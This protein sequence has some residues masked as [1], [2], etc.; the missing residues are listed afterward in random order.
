MGD[1]DVALDF[2]PAAFV[3]CV[4]FKNWDDLI[5]YIEYLDTDDAAYMEMLTQ[6]AMRA[7]YK[8]PDIGAF[9]ANIFNN[10]KQYRKNGFA[11]IYS[12]PQ[13][14]YNTFI[15]Y[16]YDNLCKG[17]HVDSANNH[18]DF[19]KFLYINNFNANKI[20][21]ED[22]LPFLKK[23][24]MDS[25][26]AN[27]ASTYAAAF[28]SP[29]ARGTQ[30]ESMLKS[31]AARIDNPA[32]KSRA[33]KWINDPALEQRYR[34]LLR[35]LW[36]QD[37][38][39]W[40]KVRVGGGADGG[41]VMLDQGHDGVAISLGIGYSA[42]WDM[43]MAQ[44]GWNIW[45]FDGTV[46]KSP[47]SHRN[48][49]FFAKNVVASREHGENEITLSEILAM[50]GDER[51]IVLQMDI[52]G[53]EWP[54]LE[55]ATTEELSRFKQIIAEFHG[56]TDPKNLERRIGILEKICKSHAPVHFHYNNNGQVMGF[57]DFLVSGL[58]EISFLQR[59]RESFT[60]SQDCY[61]TSLDRPNVARMPDVHIGR[62]TDIAKSA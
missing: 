19:N 4:D 2:N 57:S 39:G 15:K 55:A 50:T 42:P 35:M 13:V 54:L 12:Q 5:E 43:Q 51:D 44:N 30:I 37:A 8:S 17:N 32:N 56:L 24:K 18:T 21:K 28:I 46:D 38:K 1:P 41:Y 26:M 62:F 40:E 7:D 29:G 34:Q 20:Y 48:I 14:R 47:N 23:I 58:F 11:F 25:S 45:Q 36:P 10:G 27:I 59:D 9:L 52:E 3:N 33:V 31:A 60:P 6:S 22:L 16:L 49:R 61:P 53:A